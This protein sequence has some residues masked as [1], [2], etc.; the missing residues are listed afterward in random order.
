[1]SCNEH[2]V[3]RFVYHES[4]LSIL[5]LNKFW[6]SFEIGSLPKQMQVLL[7]WSFYIRI[8]LVEVT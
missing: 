3:G 2:G 4:S 1:M 5:K 8:S 7:L 6:K